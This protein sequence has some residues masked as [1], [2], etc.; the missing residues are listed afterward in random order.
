MPAG[1]KIVKAAAAAS[2]QAVTGI[3]ATAA[4]TSNAVSEATS[5]ATTGVSRLMS[6]TWNGM[7]TWYQSKGFS[8]SDIIAIVLILAVVFYV[9]SVE[10]YV[11]SP[12]DGTRS[13]VF[14]G[15]METILSSDNNGNAGYESTAAAEQ[16]R[17][18]ILKAPFPQKSNG[19]N[20]LYNL[21]YMN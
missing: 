9:F 18:V 13:K 15:R 16:R 4:A 2:N 19:G 17:D 21:F 14:G 3:Q 7:S 8:L 1:K 12:T 10:F 6:D 20:F 11:V 5:A